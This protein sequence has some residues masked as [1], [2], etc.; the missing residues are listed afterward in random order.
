MWF[1]CYNLTRDSDILVADEECE[2]DP[3]VEF[4]NNITFKF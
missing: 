3:Q 1:G 4:E 2:Y